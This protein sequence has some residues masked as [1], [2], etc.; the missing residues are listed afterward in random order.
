MDPMG[1]RIIAENQDS[2]SVVVLG[3]YTEGGKLRSTGEKIEL[4]KP[5]CVVFTGK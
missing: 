4:G 3:L 1:N 2:D 5:V